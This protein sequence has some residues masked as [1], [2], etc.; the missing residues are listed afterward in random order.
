MS[1]SE[2]GSSVVGIGPDDCFDLVIAWVV[3]ARYRF[4]RWG[5]N[6]PKRVIGSLSARR[7]VYSVASSIS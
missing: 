6:S 4:S 5:C 1:V 3:R 2:T 7:C